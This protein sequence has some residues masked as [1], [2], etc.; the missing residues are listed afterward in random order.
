FIREA[1]TPQLASVMQTGKKLGMV[2]LDDAILDLLNKGWISPEDAYDKSMD[3]KRF[4]PFLKEPPP[5]F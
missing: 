1:K 3:K 2:T 5:E 4:I